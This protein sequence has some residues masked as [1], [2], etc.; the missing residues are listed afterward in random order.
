MRHQS[1]RAI[2]AILVTFMGACSIYSSRDNL[3]E[4]CSGVPGDLAAPTQRIADPPA[5]HGPGLA[6]KP[7]HLTAI[8]KPHASDVI[9]LLYVFD[10]TGGYVSSWQRNSSLLSGD[11]FVQ[12]EN[13][14]FWYEIVGDAGYQ[15]PEL[16]RCSI[17]SMLSE[18]FSFRAP[19]GG[20]LFVQLLAPRC[21][22]CDALGSAIESVLRFNPDMSV[23]WVKINVPRNIGRLRP[24]DE[25]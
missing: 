5:T 14:A 1:L 2:S 23:R 12:A 21:T 18:P 16:D 8:A 4:E 15:I 19:P 6:G 9:P 7:E 3:P 11:L 17:A 10:E 25:R 13:D 22:E 20:L 24:R